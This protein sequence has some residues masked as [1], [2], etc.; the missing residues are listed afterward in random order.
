[1]R[2]Q[3]SESYLLSGP[4]SNT[5]LHIPGV[6]T[7]LSCYVYL[8]GD[9]HFSF[10]N[11]CAPRT[12]TPRRKCT[13]IGSFLDALTDDER[14]RRVPLE[15]DVFLEVPFGAPGISGGRKLLADP[16]DKRFDART[17]I[18]GWMYGYF[19]KRIYE[20]GE[21]S[22]WGRFHFADIRTRPDLTGLPTLE[23][24]RRRVKSRRDIRAL[25]SQIL[26]E[27]PETNRVAK[28][29][30]KLR[31]IYVERGHARARASVQGLLQ[32]YL[33]KRVDEVTQ[34][35]SRATQIGETGAG[36]LFED[37]YYFSVRTLVMDAYLTA[38]M[39]YYMFTR[40]NAGKQQ[41]LHHHRS[42]VYAGS[43]HTESIRNF[44]VEYMH[45]TPNSST[46]T[47]TY[48]TSSTSSTTST[49]S[50]TM[51]STSTMSTMSTMSLTRGR[52]PGA[53]RCTQIMLDPEV[54]RLVGPA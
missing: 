37:T 20:H 44:L 7:R 50:S 45:A 11:M 1:M 15:T 47:S 41:A 25:L 42:I 14:L 3:Q 24:F 12:C 30:H 34:S 40:S 21:R 13:N 10:D 32:E 31:S 8:L 49:T 54:R 9:H 52:R 29:F 38:R 51:S 26:Y 17:G 39:L 27:A 35:F 19:R 46:Q 22:A 18:L 4:V 53:S 28:Q 23:E 5:V 6:P 43:K 16:Q 33:D 2:T 36:K 48:A